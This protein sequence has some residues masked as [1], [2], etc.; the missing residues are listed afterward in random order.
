MSLP[1]P[2]SQCGVP[3]SRVPSLT[4]EEEEL[5]QSPWGKGKGKGVLRITQK[6]GAKH[7]AGD[8]PKASRVMWEEPHGTLEGLTEVGGCSY[9]LGVCFFSGFTPNRVSYT[10]IPPEPPTSLRRLRKEQLTVETYPW[11]L[12]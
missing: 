3:G 4:K 5:S 6:T 1:Q 2:A 11:L 8:D 9:T 7:L 10:L 12:P